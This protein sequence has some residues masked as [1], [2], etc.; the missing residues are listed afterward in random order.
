MSVME[1]VLVLFPGMM[2]AEYNRKINREEFHWGSYLG[3]V[4]QFVLYINFI[5][6]AVI[7]I[8]GWD[9]FCFDNITCGLMVKYIGF[10]ILLAYLVPLGK[11]IVGYLLKK[12]VIGE[13]Q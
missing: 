8:R 6:L 4:V 10:G 7:Y 12:Y 5:E 3:S 2:A 13:P 9:T 11:K 1:L